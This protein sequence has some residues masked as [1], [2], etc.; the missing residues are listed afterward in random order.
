[1]TYPVFVEL[2]IRK[3]EQR[4][5]FTRPFTYHRFRQS[6]TWKAPRIH[7]RYILSIRKKNGTIMI[8]GQIVDWETWPSGR[9][10]THRR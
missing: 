2:T 9:G 3:P 8:S 4:C 1:M 7:C 10:I 5:R 6:L